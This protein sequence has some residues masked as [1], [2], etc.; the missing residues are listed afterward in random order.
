MSETITIDGVIYSEDK[1]VLIKYL[2]EKHEERFYV[3]DFVEEIGAGCF[4][5]TNYTKH[6]FI[7]KNVKKIRERALGD[8]FKFVIKQ[9]YIPGTVTELEGD[10]FDHG[11]DDGGDYYSIEIVGGESGSV[12]EGYCNERGIPFVVFDPSEVEVFYSLSVDELQ[13]LARCQSQEE[14]EWII[15]ASAQGYQMNF[16]A[17]ILTLVPFENKDH[18]IIT[19][20]RIK[21]NKFRREMV[22][23]VV[24]GDGIA[25]IADFAFDDYKNLETVFVGADVCKISSTAFTGKENGDS[26][27]CPKLSSILVDE[28]NN[29]YQAID[30]VLYTLDMQTIVAYPPAKP[31]LYFEIDS[32]VKNIGAH[33]FKRANNLQCLKVGAICETIE[34]LAFLNA[35]S[36]K[37]VYFE[38][39]AIK[40]PE[41]FPFI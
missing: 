41:H 3:P 39:K 18:V 10:I 36:L 29:Y 23:R 38:N 25:E 34:E 37:H 5:D 15:Q 6:I 17:G 40:W 14:S 19:P 27:G 12:I 2:E 4:S 8:Q 11:V 16:A 28:D 21:L 33:A 35:F 26:F 1:R 31:E 30:G 20:T 9:I 13:D 22:K 7:G 24:I 32:R